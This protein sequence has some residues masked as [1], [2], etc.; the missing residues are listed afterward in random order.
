MKILLINQCFY[1][2]MASSSQHLTDLALGLI[3]GG[4][5]VTVLTGKLS[6]ND[7][8]V[9]YPKREIWKGISIIRISSTG[10]GK[11]SRWRRTADFGTFM[12]CCF[13]K[14]LIMPSYDAVVALTSPPLISVLA[15][16]FVRLKGGRL[17]FWVMDLNPDEA[18]AAGW[19]RESS[20][21]ARLLSKM[22]TSGAKKTTKLIAL[23]RFMK[24]RLT[25]KGIR[26]ERIAVIPPWSHDDYAFYSREGRTA[27]RS[28]HGLTDKFVVM[29]AGNHSPCHPLDT[30]IEAASRLAS[31]PDIHFCFIGGGS[32]Y[33]KL[34]EL[35]G[36]RALSNISFL[37]YQPLHSL[38][39]AISSADLHI[40]VMGDA[41]TGIVHPCKIY[42]I[43]AAG[44]PFL[45]IGPPESH[46]GDIVASL[47]GTDMAHSVRHGDVD[48]AIGKIM[49][50]RRTGPAV[51][52]F[53][54]SGLA[55]Q[56]SM[57]TLLTRLITALEVQSE[58]SAHSRAESDATESNKLSAV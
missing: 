22:L 13:L 36:E 32:E 17:Y 11:S 46:I 39:G 6:Y 47:N 15:A 8:R 18:I 24:E 57:H 3:R 9:S 54:Y 19:L 50:A 12:L 25:K 53:A 40:V 34:Q 4:H 35:A 33:I 45:Y 26:E 30:L 16:L 41:F 52:P 1:P 42:N 28:A 20:L 49:L 7:R 5:K 48:S 38:A 56:Y 21:A 55:E 29:Y 2:D 44:I 14:L 43:L 51:Q 58:A 31:H 37:P 27:F 10:L 23:D